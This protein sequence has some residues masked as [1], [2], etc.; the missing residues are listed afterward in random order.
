MPKNQIFSP[1]LMLTQQ[2]FDICTIQVS[3]LLLTEYLVEKL[4]TPESTV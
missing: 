3:S 2:A 1:K 4:H